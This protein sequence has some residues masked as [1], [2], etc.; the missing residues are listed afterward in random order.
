[1]DATRALSVLQRWVDDY[2]AIA[3][4]SEV[5]VAAAHAEHALDAHRDDLA[6]VQEETRAVRAMKTQ[7]ETELAEARAGQAA[8]LAAAR[9]AGEAAVA[10][11]REK[12][13]TALAGFR[14][15]VVA[16]ERH[17]QDQIRNARAEA[18]AW[19]EK[20]AGAKRA[21]DRAVAAMAEEASG[22]Q[23]TVAALQGELET[24]RSKFQALLR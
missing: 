19:T 5:L 10:T 21:H 24:T 11:A 8:A 22:L 18:A 13:E 15:G 4:L 1:M 20:A 3:S 9:E 23:A 14:P 16:A 7:A 12:A 2:A 6:R 17:A